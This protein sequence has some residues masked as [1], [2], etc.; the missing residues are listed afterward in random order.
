MS[1]ATYVRPVG[2]LTRPPARINASPDRVV[3]IGER[4]DLVFTALE[5]IQRHSDGWSDSRVISIAEARDLIA[6]Q[7]PATDALLLASDRFAAPRGAVA[8]LP[9][10][11]PRIMGIV[12]VTPDSFSDGG[13]HA[14]SAAAV[15]HAIRLV[16]DGADLLDIGGESTKPGAD[17]VPVD[18]ELA[19]VLPV[20]TGIRARSR[21]PI[22]IDTRKSEVMRQAVAA[23]ADI[24]NDVSA[25]TFDPAALMTAVELQVP[26]VLMHAQGEPKTMQDAPRYHAVT[27]DVFDWLCQRIEDCVTAGLPRR[28]LIVDPGIGFGKT[29]GHNLEL[30]A[31]LSLFHALGTPVL[32]GASR[33]RFIGEITGVTVPAERV[34]GSIGVALAAAAQGAQI[35]R[36]HDVAATRAAL[37]VWMAATTGTVATR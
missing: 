17:P 1:T 11:R 2:R 35:L 26:V 6:Q 31:G 33:K 20:I 25:L 5:L 7:S 8:G 13:V 15:A 9:L 24:V 10:D 37:D 28:L 32:V 14:A 18:V 23:G 36:V 34:S 4:E 12:N 16:T 21:V 27:L 22:S 3:R 30:L 19:R 29:T